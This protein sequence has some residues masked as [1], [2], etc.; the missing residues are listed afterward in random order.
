MQPTDMRRGS[1]QA[2]K[3]NAKVK[4]ARIPEKCKGAASKHP[5]E[6]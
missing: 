5:K 4:Q 3:R 2:T 6:M 1:Q